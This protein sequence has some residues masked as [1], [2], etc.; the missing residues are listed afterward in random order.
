MKIISASVRK[1]R[2]LCFFHK[3]EQCRFPKKTGQACCGLSRPISLYYSYTHMP[4]INTIDSCS[5]ERSHFATAL[6]P[7]FSQELTVRFLPLEKYAF[8]V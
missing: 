6:S 2:S 4:T 3:E 5:Y 8:T 7:G 1:S